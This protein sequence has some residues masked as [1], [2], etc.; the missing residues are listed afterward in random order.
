AFGLGGV[1]VEVLQDVAFRVAPLTDRDAREMVRETRGYT[2]LTGYRGHAEGDVE[3][4]EDALLRLSRLVE[5][6]PEITQVDLNPIFAMPPGEGYRIADARIEVAG[7]RSHGRAPP[8][9]R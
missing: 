9:R 5:R 7:S 6:T 1:H 4:L 3:A 8:S 2:L